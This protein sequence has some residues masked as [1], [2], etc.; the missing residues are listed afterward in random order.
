VVVTRL[1]E[2]TLR[3]L[4]D[5]AGGIYRP[6]TP[7]GRELQQLYE[8]T[9]QRHAASEFEGGS[10]D[11]SDLTPYFALLA[12]LA[13]LIEWLVPERKAMA[14]RA[15]LTPSILRDDRGPRGAGRVKASA[16][17]GLPLAVLGLAGC[18]FASVAAFELNEQGS[19]LYQE[20]RFSEALDRFRRAQV[21][22]PDLPQLDFNAGTG[23]YQTDE[24]ER[25]LRETQRALNAE[26]P[27]ARAAAHYNMGNTYFRMNRFQDAYEEY[28][29]A[30]RENPTDV[31]PKVNLELALHRL[32]QQ[33]QQSGG[34]G[35]S[36]QPNQG[37]PGQPQAGQGPSS[38]QTAPGRN[39]RSQDSGENLRQALRQAG[40]LSIEE[41]LRVL[42]ILRGREQEFQRRYHAAPS[43]R[44]VQ[45]PERD[46]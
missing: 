29:R 30:L 13:L 24:L 1:Q 19:Q 12:F 41:A 42:D 7:G 27:E 18:T 14:A 21:E 11:S 32:R 43:N 40:E 5:R 36:Q 38:Q 26:S 45:R 35:N 33:S 6:G 28:K 3:Q 22:R 4:T 16:L 39:D 37:Q 34:Q 46:W 44:A 8:A 9:A 31:D 20:G 15:A 23:L 2:D 25:A 10:R 17:G